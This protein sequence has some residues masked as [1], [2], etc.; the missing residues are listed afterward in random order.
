MN[1]FSFVRRVPSFHARDQ[2]GIALA[3]ALILLIVVT[4]LGMAAVRGTIMQQKMT[5]NYY[6][7]ELAFQAAEAALRQGETAV[8]ASSGGLGS[9]RDCQSTSTNKC[10]PDPFTDSTVTPTKVLSAN[11][12]PGA[13][14][15][16][17]VAAKQPQYVVEYLGKFNI[18]PPNV[19]QISN[20]SG[21]GPCVTQTQADFYRI[22]ARSGPADVQGRA[23]V[24]LQTV[25][26][27]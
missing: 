6:D 21:Y 26:R 23:T 22:T 24:T 18:P 25:F 27:R 20:C 5:S 15:G 1:T 19:S 2:R 3:T 17:G 16:N 9:F 10:V 13:L 7:R 8:T 14:M 11:F 4:L 12:N